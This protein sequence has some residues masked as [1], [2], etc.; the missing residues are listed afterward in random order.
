ML[1]SS[2]YPQYYENLMDW[3]D[4]FRSVKF[5]GTFV[6]PTL[7]SYSWSILSSSGSVSLYNTMTVSPTFDAS[8]GDGPS[9]AVVE[10]EVVDS[11]FHPAHATTTVK[12]VNVPPEVHPMRLEDMSGKSIDYFIPVL[13]EYVDYTVLADFTDA[14]VQDWHTAVIDWADG[15][16]NVS[17]DGVLLLDDS[18]GGATGSVEAIHSYDES[19]SYS[20]TLTVED[21]DSEAGGATREVT[22]VDAYQVTELCVEELVA[23]LSYPE[24]SAKA[25][26][27]IVKAL[28][29]LQGNADGEEENGALDK[30]AIG[31]LNSGLEKIVHAVSYLADAAAVDANHV[32]VLMSLQDL[33][34][35]AAESITRKA[36]DTVANQVISPDLQSILEK[37]L[38]LIDDAAEAQSVGDF[39]S[40]VHCY[41]DAYRVVKDLL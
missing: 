15:S 22:V 37:A 31:E 17:S 25:A 21:K 34:T 29:N 14:G 23:L 36:V 27:Y 28:A 32:D 2:G 19:G 39:V 26:K 5:N 6:Q 8:V 16:Q 30:I 13:L 40:A 33:T 41:L 1:E 12:I 35:K 3:N 24:L 10:L 7:E 18:L 11:T 4:L 38:F 20:I 9:E